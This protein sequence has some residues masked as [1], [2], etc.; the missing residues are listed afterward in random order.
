M[1]E[2]NLL[3][4]AYKNVVGNKR[5]SWRTFQEGEKGKDA[6]KYKS[7]AKL[8]EGELVGICDEV[9]QLLANIVDNQPEDDKSDQ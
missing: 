2:R 1:E 8:I 3:S 6:V 9:L 5:Q 7:Y 4:V